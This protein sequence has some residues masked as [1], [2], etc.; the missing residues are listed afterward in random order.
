MLCQEVPAIR[1][2]LARLS[3]PRAG[4]EIRRLWGRLVRRLHGG[5]NRTVRLEPAGACRGAVLLGNMIDAFP[6]RQDAPV[7]HGHTNLWETRQMAETFRE[8][9]FAVDVIHWSRSAPPPPGPYAAYTDLRRN[10]ERFAPG[11]N[12][13]CLKI[14]HIDT[15]HHAVYNA[16]Q[17]RRLREL[18]ARR[19]IR[20]QPFKMLEVNRS[21]EAADC[22][23]M[24]GND[25]TAGTYGFAGKPL[26]RIPISSP[27]PYPFPEDKDWAAARRRFLWFGSEG[28]V[29]KGLDLVLDAFAGLPELHLTV[30]GPLH[31]EPAFERAYRRELYATP[32]IRTLG[33]VDVGGPVFAEIA[34]TTLALVYPTSSEGQSGGVVNCLHAGLIPVAS[35][36]CGVDL[37][38]DYAVR[39]RDC[40]VESIRAQAGELA[41]RPPR[42]LE[43]MARSAWTYARTHHTRDSFAAAYRD[44]VRRL[45]A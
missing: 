18:E 31:R 10:F 33:W 17:Q 19:G 38:P 11:M 35:F 7:P 27:F 30:C 9:D 42:E 6:L 12:P 28:F 2:T 1:Q 29:H 3:P 8:L 13:G 36:E 43:A 45:L 5:N 39:L 20:L 37:P 22:A 40:S 34:R 16:G 14:L 41:A 25:F 26:Y 32:N 4:R 24:L 15:A 23:T 44:V 21:I